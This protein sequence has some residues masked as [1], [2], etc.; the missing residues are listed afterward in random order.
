[1]DSRAYLRSI[2]DEFS[3]V[4]NRVRNLIGSTHWPSDGAAKESILR[5]V[6]RRHVPANIGIGTGFVID[7]Q[8][9]SGQIDVLLFNTAKPVLYRDGDFICV[10]PDAVEGIIEVK[11][12]I[13]ARNDLRSALNS[14]SDDAFF[15]R[16]AF[17]RASAGHVCRIFAAL[18]THET[19]L[20]QPNGF[21]HDFQSVAQGNRRRIVNFASIGQDLFAR[22]WESSPSTAEGDYDH[23]HSYQLRRLS[24]GYFVNNVVEW[25]DRSSVRRNRELCFLPEGKELQ[26][27]ERVPLALDVNIQEVEN[28]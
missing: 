8:G 16:S 7:R 23:W 13:Q 27:I 3:A 18:F 17:E 21:V 5:A 4:K 28:Q 9:C 20:I 12:R 25:L 26:L 10:T 6:L 14:L 2:A 22:L 15:I 24:P 19:G 1:M 11:S